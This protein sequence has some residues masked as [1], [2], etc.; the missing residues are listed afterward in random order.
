MLSLTDRITSAAKHANSKLFDI[1]LDPYEDFYSQGLDSLD[2][3]Q[4]I[5]KV[6]E[7]FGITIS[8]ADY[9][10]CVSIERIENF[11]LGKGRPEQV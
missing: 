4:I 9:D 11:L 3:V 10:E 2:H 1:D 7:E 6:E 8:D 5:M